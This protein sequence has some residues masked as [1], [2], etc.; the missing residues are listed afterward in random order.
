[1]TGLA[2]REWIEGVDPQLAFDRGLTIATALK[3]DRQRTK[4]LLFAALKRLWQSVRV[5][6]GKTWRT[7]EDLQDCVDDIIDV[8]R[9]LKVEEVLLV[10]QAIRRGNTKIYGRLDTPTILEALQ[11]HDAHCT[12]AFRTRQQTGFGDISIEHLDGLKEMA[13]R[14]PKRKVSLQEAFE[15]PSKISEDERKAM[16]ERDRERISGKAQG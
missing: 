9:T 16:R 13:E 5:G 3:A 14:L 8:Y 10:F 12:T 11:A 7:D 1:M 15:Q 6:E 2:N 4:I